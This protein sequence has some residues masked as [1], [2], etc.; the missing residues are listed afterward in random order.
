MAYRSAFL[1]LAAAMA[2]LAGCSGDNNPVRDIVAG[3][4]A[5]PTFAKSPDFV[6]QTRPAQ[7]DY[8]PIGTRAPPRS[9]KARTAAEVQ[10]AQAEMDAARSANEAAGAAASAQAASVTPAAP[11]PGAVPAA[12]PAPA[13][14]AAPK[15]KPRRP[16]APAQ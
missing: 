2:V 14:A 8:V 5:G 13:P 12:V 4:G 3:V 1:S 15:P 7:I 6:V 16:A 9:E 10:A 11:A